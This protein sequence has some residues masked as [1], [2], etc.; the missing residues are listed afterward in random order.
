MTT[1]QSLAARKQRATRH[2]VQTRALYRYEGTRFRDSHLLKVR[3]IK[4]LRR[5]TARIW[6]AEKTARPDAAPAIIAGRGV[7]QS[8][9]WLSYCEGRAKIVL[10]RHERNILV[11]IHELTHA[12]GFTHHGTA[13]RERYFGL[14]RR[15]AGR[16]SRDTRAALKVDLSTLTAPLLKKKRAS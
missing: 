10:A 5:L 16:L 13:F 14:L 3:S 15:Y 9:R 7:Y 4:E 11:L 8:G 6:Q 1:R 2:A 12:I